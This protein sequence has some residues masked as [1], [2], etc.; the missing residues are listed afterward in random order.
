MAGGPCVVTIGPKALHQPD[1]EREQ[2]ELSPQ[3]LERAS[4]REKKGRGLNLADGTHDDRCPLIGLH[5]GRTRTLVFQRAPVKT[6]VDVKAGLSES[7]STDQ[8]VRSSSCSGTGRALVHLVCVPPVHALSPASQLPIFHHVP[9][10]S[11]FT[12]GTHSGTGGQER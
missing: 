8:R 1:P 6:E 12:T 9:V 5:S 3:R 4:L 10:A 7:G 2:R 11:A